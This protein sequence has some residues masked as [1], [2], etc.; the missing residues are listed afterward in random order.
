MKKVSKL[1][2][3]AL[4]LLIS[5]SLLGCSSSSFKTIVKEENETQGEYTDKTV[6]IHTNDIHGGFIPDAQAGT[7]GGLEGYAAIS[8]LKKEYEAKGATVLLVDDGDFSQGSI[9][10]ALNKG[11]ASAELMEK[12]GYDI[13][14]IGNHEFDNGIDQLK[15]NLSDKS[16][17]T[18]CSNIFD[19]DKTIFDSEAIAKIGKLK[20]GFFALST[21]ETQT[22]ALPSLIEGLTFTE[23]EEMYS[24]AQKEVDLLR[25]ESDLVICLSHLGTNTESKGNRSY[26]VYENVEGIDFII[27]GHSHTVMNRGENNEPIQS[28]GTKC[29]NIGVIV[30][31]NKTKSIEDNYLVK[32]M[33]I[34]ADEEILDS[35][36]KI[37]SEIDEEYGSIFANT[38][39]ELKAVKEIV[40]TS[41][42]N[43]GDLVVDAM[44]WEA[45]KS[46]S[47]EVDD[48][49]IVAV[50]NSG[51]IRASIL[52]GGISM[53]D[54]NTALPFVNTVTV[55]YITGEELLEALEASTFCT[56]DPVGGFPQISRFKF[57]IDT[58][59]VFDAG[60]E[61]P[62][63]TYCKPNSINRVTID[64]INGKPFNP[65]DT[66]AL[67][68][69]DF[70]ASGG[71]TYYAFKRGFDEGKGFDTGLVLDE[72]VIDYINN[73]LEGKIP[74]SYENP[75]GR[76]TIIK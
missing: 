36:M 22:K 39:F 53:K 23:K 55:V 76:I 75:Q 33:D 16:Y 6:I 3:T 62:N 42:T 57:T 65:K 28:T 61:Y 70:C 56:P 24:I 4:T 74:S 48:D 5:I 46:G 63:S 11:E 8:S 9:Y 43:F 10:V 67:I 51:G 73:E 69:S 30:I 13:V 12:V 40:R 38:D 68:T 25:K 27:D 37:M 1:I 64:E 14:S 72:T 15:S 35:C 52:P 45:C 60:D 18:L 34:K 17:L 7:D 41:E 20:I 71:D 19:G 31:D 44:V 47:L 29:E 26:D 32:T 59:K 50:A 66:Y 2:I 49:H 54:I 58:T 21:P